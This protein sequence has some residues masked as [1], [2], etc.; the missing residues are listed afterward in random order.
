M[1]ALLVVY[2]ADPVRGLVGLFTN[3]KAHEGT[4]DL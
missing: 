2:G 4:L 3:V 1:K